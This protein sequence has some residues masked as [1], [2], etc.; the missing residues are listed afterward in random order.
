MGD[1]DTVRTWFSN[2][3]RRQGRWRW[4]KVVTIYLIAASPAVSGCSRSAST[5]PVAPANVPDPV[6]MAFQASAIFPSGP[7]MLQ[8]VGETWPPIPAPPC[9]PLFG[10]EDGSSVSTP[11]VVEE[12]ASGW[13]IRSDP[14]YGDIEFALQRTGRTSLYGEGLTGSIRGTGRDTSVVPGA[15]VR[16]L[17]VTMP[18]SPPPLIVEGTGQTVV[19]RMEGT[20]QGPTTFHDPRGGHIDCTLLRWFLVPTVDLH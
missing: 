9:Q 14:A 13:L 8:V 1:S 4:C 19:A 16:R 18:P 12:Q 15:L 10:T 20:I 17:I 11:V 3:A 2:P 7:A 5:S 6:A